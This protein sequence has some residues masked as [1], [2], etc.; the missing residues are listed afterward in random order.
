MGKWPI[1]IRERF[2]PG[3]YLP[4]ILL[5]VGVNLLYAQSVHGVQTLI[6]DKIILGI[7]A[8]FFFF[9]MRLFDEIK[10]YDLDLIINPHRPL[11][12]GLLSVRE[13]KVSILFIIVFELFLAASFGTVA[14]FAYAFALFYSLLMYEE[15][16]IG[17]FLRPHLTT[18]AVTH[19]IVIAMLGFSLIALSRGS[20]DYQNQDLLFLS[21][22]WFIFNLFEFARKT[23]DQAEERESVASYSKI[24]TQKG[25][26]L[27]SLS[28]VIL[29]VLSLS[30]VF[31]HSQ[32]LPFFVLGG[33]YTLMILS[34][35][36]GLAKV[37]GKTFRTLSTL[38]MA[39]HYLLLFIYLWRLP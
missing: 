38:Y 10:D 37:R 35:G 29:G 22:H 18:Y 27:L 20:L 19:T 30:L 7:M 36:F 1:F 15:F 39:I 4:L 25:A 32:S 8:F 21:S 23:F 34:H 14:F 16:F 3:E 17:D 9:R 31:G 28:Q 5:F 13:V 33:L 11:A 26:Y 24:F 6:Q 2:K 12:R